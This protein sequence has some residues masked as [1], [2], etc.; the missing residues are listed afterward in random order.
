MK[1]VNIKETAKEELSQEDINQ[2]LNA[3]SLGE[4]NRSSKVMNELIIKCLNIVETLEA[5]NLLKE[6]AE[7]YL[8][9]VN[10][11]EN[12]ISQ[13]FRDLKN[14][15]HQLRKELD[16]VKIMEYNQK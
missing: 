11:R 3:I 10:E 13:D 12:Y 2:L 9:Y 16:C 7:F 14:L 1:K 5:V 15:L 4:T 6:K 8:V